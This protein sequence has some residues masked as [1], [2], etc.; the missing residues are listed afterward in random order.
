MSTN[1]SNDTDID[2]DINACV[3]S[4]CEV[5]PYEFEPLAAGAVPSQSVH[6]LRPVT[7]IDPKF[8]QNLTLQ[9]LVR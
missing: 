6:H 9:Q 2:E 1:V 8:R 7:V 4:T 3:S 5:T